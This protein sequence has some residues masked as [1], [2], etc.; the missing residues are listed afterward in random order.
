[1]TALVF[2]NNG[3]K[4]YIGTT[5]AATTVSA[6]AADTWTEVTG[7]SDIGD[8]GD[9]ANEIKIDI[10]SDGR[11]HKA[12]GTFDAGTMQLKCAY[13]S[14]DAGQAA[15]IA[16]VASPLGYNFKVVGNDKIT[17]GGTNSIAY[18]TAKVMSK[19]LGHGTANNVVMLNSSLAI[20]SAVLSVSAT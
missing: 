8:F 4:I 14:T 17:S 3:T 6:Y 19:S 15:L 1:M 7:A 9:T 16:A 18:F 20:D 11:T 10:I 2:A 5:V 12:K 13:N